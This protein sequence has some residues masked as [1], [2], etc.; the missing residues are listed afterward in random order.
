[1]RSSTLLPNPTE[2]EKKEDRGF[3]II[4]LE[5]SLPQDE[6]QLII[7]LHKHF[8]T[9]FWFLDGAPNDEEILIDLFTSPIRIWH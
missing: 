9:N 7:R 6:N 5:T 4:E 1:M 2:L 3:P 8:S